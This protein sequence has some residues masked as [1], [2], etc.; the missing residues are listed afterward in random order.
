M[1][2]AGGPLV[3]FS[4]TDTVT[5]AGYALPQDADGIVDGGPVQRVYPR[6]EHLLPAW[7]ECTCGVLIHAYLAP[8]ARAGERVNADDDETPHVCGRPRVREQPDVEASETWCPN[9][10]GLVAI[11]LSDRGAA[12]LVQRDGYR[13]WCQ[14]SRRQAASPRAPQPVS[15]T[16]EPAPIW[17]QYET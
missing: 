5:E 9:C 17:K 1:R 13:H 7:Q 12:R 4:T 14:M 10:H 16:S 11:V 2:V 6:A 15:K 8:H 3:R